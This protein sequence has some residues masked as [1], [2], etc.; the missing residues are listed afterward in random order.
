MMIDV[1][2][3]ETGEI[4]FKELILN[5]EMKVLSYHTPW[6]SLTVLITTNTTNIRRT[7][8]LI[9]S[10]SIANDTSNTFRAMTDNVI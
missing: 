6:Y 7:S 10:T 2:N 4:E 3:A 9:A 1:R 8:M 5:A